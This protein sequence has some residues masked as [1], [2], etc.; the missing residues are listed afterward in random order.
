MFGQAAGF[1]FL[2]ALSPG[3]VVVMT[4]FLG[5]ASPRRTALLFLLGALVISVAKRRDS[6][7][8]S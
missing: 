5:S 2:A 4:G 6:S 3:A 7:A 8:G 1:A